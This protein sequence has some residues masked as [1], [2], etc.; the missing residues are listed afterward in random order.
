MTRTYDEDGQ[1]MMS[2]NKMVK[3]LLDELPLIRKELKQE[4]AS[5][6]DIAGMEQRLTSKIDAVTSDLKG[7]RFQVHQNHAPFIEN[8]MD[9]EKRLTVLETA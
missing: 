5:K 9:M 8:Q 1:P 7:L 2:T 6:E 3:R 4:L